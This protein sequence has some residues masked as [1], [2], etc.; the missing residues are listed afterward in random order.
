MV[1]VGMVSGQ[2]A[3]YAEVCDGVTAKDLYRSELDYRRAKDKTD[4]SLELYKFYVNALYVAMSRA[5]Q[6]LTIVEADIGHPIFALLGLQAGEARTSGTQASTKEEWAQEARKLELQGKDEQARA[7]RETFLQGK[8]VPWTPWSRALI[9]DLAPK[10]LDPANPSSKLR[11]TLFDYA[12]WHGQQHWIERL[13]ATPFLPA[14]GLVDLG[15]FN[16]AGTTVLKRM[17]MPEWDRLEAHTRRTVAATHQR[18]LQAYTTRNFKDILRLCDVHGV[19]HHTPVGATPLMLAARAGNVPLVQALLA[20]G[21]DPDRRDEFGHTA[22][23]HAASRAMAESGF[24]ISGLPALYDLLAPAVLDVQTDGRLVRIEQ[25]QGEYW[26]LTLMLAGL[27]TQ[28]SA[29]VLRSHEVWKYGDGVFAEQ[30]HL[31][32]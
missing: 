18:H 2:R 22:W 15:S 12:L 13:A 23:L 14:K 8:P 19:D 24:A 27:K 16:M 32:L 6:S 26:V 10:A 21:A 9:E 5:V 30:L 3:A 1:L 31:V 11:Q 7:I 20:K 4:K 17:T 25:H 29:C 28:W